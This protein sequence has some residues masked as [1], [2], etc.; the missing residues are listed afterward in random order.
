MKNRRKREQRFS[1]IDEQ[2]IKQIN[3]HF[4]LNIYTHIF[5]L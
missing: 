3:T 5:A 1:N 4:T 2:Q